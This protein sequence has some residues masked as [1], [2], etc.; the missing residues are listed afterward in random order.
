MLTR[1]GATLEQIAAAAE[2][3]R[4][5]GWQR[6]AGLAAGGASGSGSSSE[7]GG[8]SSDAPGSGRPS[9]AAVATAIHNCHYR[10]YL[11]KMEAEV[12]ELRRDEAL[13][14]PEGL[15]YG[16]LQLSAEDR[17]KLSAARP[18]SLAAAMRIPGVTPTALLLL[19]QHVR[20][21]QARGGSGGVGGEGR[22]GGEGA[23]HA[24]Q[25][26]AAEAGTGS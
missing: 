20:K 9:P 8:H 4:A 6:L 26:A 23:A 24:V 22:R 15:D 18:A 14:I 13:R 16:A 1:P 11:R 7:G 17:E 5:P 19:L 25:E 2:A 3:E 10:P 12:A 21:R